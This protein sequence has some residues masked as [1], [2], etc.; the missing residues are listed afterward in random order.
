MNFQFTDLVSLD[1]LNR[2]LQK[3]YEATDFPCGII[4]FEG[5]ELA[6][7]E[8][9][10]V[11]TYFHKRNNVS[12]ARCQNSNLAVNASLRKLLVYQCENGL[13]NIAAPISVNGRHMVN[14]IAGPIFFKTPDREYFQ[15]Q[16]LECGFNMEA[17]LEA[18]NKVP[19]IPENKARKSMEYCADFI[20]MLAE[21]GLKNLEEKESKR[22]MQQ[23]EAALRASEK[24][25]NI[26]L[27]GI[28]DIVLLYEID[29]NFRFKIKKA[30]NVAIKYLNSAEN[31]IVGKNIEEVFPD[32][33]APWIEKALKVLETGN[34]STYESEQFKN[35]HVTLIPTTNDYSK[36]LI[37]VAKDISE[38]K[39]T[40]EYR[41]RVEKLESVGLLA[42]GIAHD[43]NNF[44]TMIMGNTSLLKLKLNKGIYQDDSIVTTL[45]QIE[46][47]CTQ[48][49]SL[50]HQLLTFA[51]GGLPLVKKTSIQKLL[52]E[53]SAF[54][55]RGSNLCCQYNMAHDLMYVE[56][57]EGQIS[58][59]IFNMVLN[60][61]H[62]MPTGGEITI[63]AEN[64]SKIPDAE[65]KEETLSGA[66][67]VKISITDNG[68]GIPEDDLL[69]I[70][71]PY[72]T[73]KPKGSGL[74]LT[75]SY[76]IIKN[77]GGCIT[78][79]STIGLGTTFNIYLQGFE[80]TEQITEVDGKGNKMGHG[81]VLVMDDQEML[82][83]ML[84]EVLT[85]LGYEAVCAK[86][87][88]EAVALYKKHHAEFD[89]VI[90]D[91]TV[92]GGMGGKAALEKIIEYNPDVKAIVSSGY[93]NNEIM[94]NYK[95]YGFG[96]ILKK[97]YTIEEVTE[98]LHSMI[99]SRSVED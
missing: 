8:I 45:S 79:D 42:G 12:K 96:G 6:T 78:V 69:K 59:V 85:A 39:K 13:A 60:A 77:H 99:P 20:V 89:V 94:A 29:S 66:G 41:L 43:F 19:I 61:R 55:L 18:V 70:F 51:R 10:D 9:G 56:I 14:L 90:L 74:G 17:Y 35:L 27:N 30:N 52:K 58:Q 40:E 82:R 22:K 2:T 93:S 36:H 15:R 32:A 48:A 81:K 3:L 28:S 97:P 88:D 91:L 24:E 11:C 7:A 83:E 33:I 25:Y 63:S 44:L 4:T 23:V 87:G 37:V 72:F 80:P 38:R 67:Y 47:A 86:D 76:S 21:L 84:Y 53:S 5:K 54:A 16:A 65:G 71:D 49:K 92:P 26:L 98:V 34:P 57:D 64:V 46:K 73:T 68:A 31:D 95:D 62:A 1:D 50:T 75:T